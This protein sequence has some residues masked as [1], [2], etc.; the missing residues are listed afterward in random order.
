MFLGCNKNV[1]L[2]LPIGNPNF[3]ESLHFD[4]LFN[5]GLLIFYKSS[6]GSNYLITSWGSKIHKD[7][8]Q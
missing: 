6:N 2:H 4:L 3:K 5:N 1:L 7:Y 8:T